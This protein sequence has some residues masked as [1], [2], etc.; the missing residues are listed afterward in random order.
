M[1]VVRYTRLVALGKRM[2]WVLVALMLIVVVWIVSDNTGD[3][4]SRIVFSSI[5]KME[6]LQNVMLKPHYQ[7][8]DADNQPYTVIADKATQ[9]DKDSVDLENIT[10]DML[11]GDGKWLAL[12]AKSGQLNTASKQLLLEGDIN[13]FYDGGIEFETSRANIDIGR[14]AAYG[15][16][17]IKGQGP[18]GTIKAKSFEVSDHGKSIRFNGSVRMKLYR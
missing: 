1:S 13:L 14:G 15:D 3:N 7:G 11:R 8:V 12:K 18:M 17:P 10:A 5:S 6:A 4:G 9:R 2:L 16:K